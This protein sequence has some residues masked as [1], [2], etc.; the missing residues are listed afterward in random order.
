M[1]VLVI[2][3]AGMLG[4][5]MVKV[6]KYNNIDLIISN[7]SELDIT[8]IDATI[9]YI[10]LN[11]PNVVI[12]CAAYTNVDLCEVEI[13]SAYKVNSIGA[14]NI[15]VAC[16]L[17]DASM[18]HISTDYIFDGTENISYKEDYIKFNPLNIYGKSK[19]DGEINVRTM[20]NKHYII[21]TQW[22]YGFS[23][24]NFVKTMINI[25]KDKKK[26]NVVSDQYGSPT[27][28]KDLAEMIFNIIQKPIYGV[29][30]VTNS[31]HTSWYEFTLEIFKQANITDV[32]VNPCTTEEFVRPANRPK[33]NVLDGFNLKLNNIGVLR[34]YKD[35][36][37]DY[38][39]EEKYI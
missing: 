5:D 11:K 20:C 24:N 13:D 30:N 16:N 39:K 35:A 26:L 7:K 14:R 31:E 29:Y 1:K 2:G 6:L 22:L 28:T 8:D 38:L 12:N 15:A 10:L 21:R 36:L 3:S 37:N 27:Y 4:S 25:S 17:I 32:E 19:L 33:N 34:S 18:V 23:G 9:Q